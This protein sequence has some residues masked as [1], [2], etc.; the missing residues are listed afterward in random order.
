[1]LHCLVT[2]GKIVQDVPYLGT[3]WDLLTLWTSTFLRFVS[4]QWVANNLQACKRPKKTLILYEFEACPYCRRVREALTHLD[5]DCIIYPCP[6]ETL[7]SRGF[8]DK[9]RFRPQANQLGGKLQFPLL[10]DENQT[11]NNGPL[12]LYESEVIVDYLWKTYGSKASP[13]PTYTLARKTEWYGLPLGSLLRCMPQHGLLRMPSKKP[14]KMLE[15]WSYEPSPFSKRVREILS[16]LEL[17]YYLR[18]A[19]RGSVKRKEF[20]E[21]FGKKNK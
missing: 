8:V 7:K 21:R 11:I 5:L 18:N 12:I 20:R 3:F 10:V 4:G 15:L 14:E 1:L 13:T 16:S 9:S 17:P 2:I 6:R 19:A